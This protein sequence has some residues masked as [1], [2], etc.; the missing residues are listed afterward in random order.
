MLSSERLRKIVT[1]EVAGPPWDL[2][3]DCVNCECAREVGWQQCASVYG[4][5]RDH[6]WFVQ[7]R[8]W[9]ADSV[10]GIEDWGEG[11]KILLE[12]EMTE[13]AVVKRCFV[14]MRDFAEHEVREGFRWKGRSVLSPHIDIHALYDA[15]LT[16]E[17]ISV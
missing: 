11:S 6:V 10:T 1:Q 8:L 7:A 9:R 13:G 14:A 4:D 15:A 12:H 2:R 5:E 17:D 16:I 3:I